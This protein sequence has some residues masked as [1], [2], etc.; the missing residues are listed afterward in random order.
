MLAVLR[1]PAARLGRPAATLACGGAATLIG[2]HIAKRS[3][4]DEFASVSESELPL[5]YNPEQIASV[6]RS[7]PRC[8]LSR[9]ATITCRLVPFGSRVLLDWI[10]LDSGS[11]KACERTAERAREFRLLLTDLGPTL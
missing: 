9:L 7:H 3:A 6:W 10:T 4:D 11:A 5:A 1:R 8:V 2:L